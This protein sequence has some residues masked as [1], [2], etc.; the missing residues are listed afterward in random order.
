MDNYCPFLAEAAGRD[1]VLYDDLAEPGCFTKR[2]LAYI[3]ATCKK[4]F[5]SNLSMLFVPKGWACVTDD[6]SIL[7]GVI[8][9]ERPDWRENFVVAVTR[10]G[11]AIMARY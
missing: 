5:R 7:D 1:L 9:V 4:S 8:I 2:L 11:E 6:E 3:K 10:C